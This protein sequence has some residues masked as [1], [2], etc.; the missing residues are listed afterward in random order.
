[1]LPTGCR[2]SGLVNCSGVSGGRCWRVS[3][4]TP[5]AAA[6]TRDGGRGRNRE[7]AFGG[8]CQSNGVADRAE[9]RLWMLSIAVRLPFED[10]FNG[11]M[12]CRDAKHDVTV[13]ARYSHSLYISLIVY[14]C[15]TTH[16]DRSQLCYIPPGSF[17]SPC[18]TQVPEPL[19]EPSLLLS[20][21]P[22][23][24]PQ[25]SPP[26]RRPTHSGDPLDDRDDRL[27]RGGALDTSGVVAFNAEDDPLRSDPT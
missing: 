7:A 9:G 27:Q 11:Q 6:E 15:S 13:E 25:S 2:C 22:Q 19:I 10:M 5:V 20:R 4:M 3:G 17:P 21:N 16:S 12:F 1:M 8:R 14:K 24:R 26:G 18:R 23:A